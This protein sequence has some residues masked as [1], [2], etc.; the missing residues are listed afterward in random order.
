[1]HKPFLAA[2]F[3][4]AGLL[5]CTA[6]PAARADTAASKHS[7]SNASESE[8]PALP[9]EAHKAQ[10]IGVDGRTLRYT[11]SVGWLPVRDDS[12]KT[13]AQVVLPL[14]RCPARTGR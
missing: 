6:A 12:G 8:R 14:T 1:M 3:A 10:S 7:A 9:A 13:I 11:V 5:T 4:V 2:A